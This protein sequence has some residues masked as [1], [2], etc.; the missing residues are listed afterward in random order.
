MIWGGFIATQKLSLIHMPPNRHTIVD[1]VEIV[2]DEVLDSF[3]KEQEG[4][5]K[6]VLMEDGTPMHRDKVAKDWREN[7]NLEKIK[8][9]AQSP[10]LNSIKNV[11]KLFK[12]AMQKRWRAKNQ[13]DMQ[14]AVESKWKAILQCKLEALA[15]IM[16]QRIKDV[17][18]VGS[19]STY[20]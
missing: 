20:W 14:L 18:V 6:V 17:I 5:C 4:V 10:D 3:L 1:Y 11:W 15:A 2:Y 7:D 9:L 8:W 12:D 16:P 13:E 19:S